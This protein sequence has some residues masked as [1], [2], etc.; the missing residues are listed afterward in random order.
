M[1]HWK[2]KE[3]GPTGYQALELIFCSV[4]S[5][6][7]EWWSVSTSAVVS[8]P[9]VDSAVDRACSALDEGAEVETVDVVVESVSSVTAGFAASVLELLRGEE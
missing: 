9:S 2:F 5:H 3:T 6:L 1:G 7:N 4:D 8:L